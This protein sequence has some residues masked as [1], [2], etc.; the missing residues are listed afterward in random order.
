M[1][2]DRLDAELDVVLFES[3][4]LSK[5]ALESGHV[6][7]DYSDKHQKKLPVLER[8]EFKTWWLKLQRVERTNLMTRKGIHPRFVDHKNRCFVRL[9]DLAM[10]DLSS[11]RRSKKRGAT[12][13]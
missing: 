7:N 2:E 10:N 3:Y 6:A 12:E 9:E 13:G 11:L 5:P 1:T 8:L 4:E